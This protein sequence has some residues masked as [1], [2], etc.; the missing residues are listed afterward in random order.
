[1][2]GLDHYLLVSGLLFALGLVGVAL[3]RSA[4]V[5]LM[6]LEMTLNAANLAAVAFSHY[7]GRAEGQILVFFTIVIA[8]AEVAVGLAIFVALFRQKQTVSLDDLTSM[9]S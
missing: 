3:R 5:T 9:R 2:V 7:L 1:M 8:A 4:L 6:C